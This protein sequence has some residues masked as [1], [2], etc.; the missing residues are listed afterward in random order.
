M[1]Q[2]KNITVTHKKDM[3]EIIRDFSFSLRPEDKAVIIGEEGNGKSTLLKLIYQEAMVEG[4]AD[5]TGEIIKGQ[6]RLGYLAQELPPGQKEMQVA[7]YF[8]GIPA[9][10]EKTPKELGELAKT[11]GISHGFFY[12]DREIRTL[13]GGEKVKMQLAGILLEQPDVLLL[14]EPSND[15][16]LETLEWLEGFLIGCGLPVLYVSHD[17]TF[18]ERTA[19]VIIHLEQV[20]RKSAAKRPAVPG[21]GCPQGAQ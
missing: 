6:A 14:D 12:E 1:L 10:F 20:R 2:L 13:S 4:Y 5:Y 8:Y 9:F 21:A 11:L 15:I 16:D 18:I 17:E 19:N 3:R 7:Q